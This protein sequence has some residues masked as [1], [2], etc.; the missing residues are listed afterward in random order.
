MSLECLVF[1]VGV[2][3]QVTAFQ[4]WYQVAIGRFVAGLGVG[5]L[6]AAVPLYQAETA[7]KSI[8]GSLTA[9]Y[10]LFITFGILVAYC[11]SI[12]TRTIGNSGSWRIVIAL[13]IVFAAIL[14]IGELMAGSTDPLSRQNSFDIAHGLNRRLVCPTGIQFMP[15]SPRWLL[16]KGRDADAL[17]SIQRV[18][19]VK[20]DGEGSLTN[21]RLERPETTRSL[22]RTCIAS[23]NS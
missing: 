22:T 17:R 3:I 4:A 16:R 8:R 13:G 12:G 10:Q 23:R 2:I 21:S 18:K 19:S 20:H 14:G 9:T 5:A 6:S 7:P 15:E 1:T 11:F